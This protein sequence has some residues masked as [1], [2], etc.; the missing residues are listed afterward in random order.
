MGFFKKKL[1]GIMSRGFENISADDAK[2]M[3]DEGNVEI[4][5]V[6][7][8]AEYSEGKIEGH[9]LINLNSGDFGEKIDQLDKDKS[10][11]VY[12]RAG[13]RSAVAA[14]IM[15]NKGFGKVY[16]MEGGIQKWNK[17]G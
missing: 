14:G 17:L 4:I 2:K 6:R 12:C 8:E 5:D 3:I 10:Y 16:N 1:Q 11:V 13:G 15:A 7:S 9:R